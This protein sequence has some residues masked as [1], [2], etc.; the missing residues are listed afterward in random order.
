MSKQNNSDY[1]LSISGWISS[2][3]IHDTRQVVQAREGDVIL[4]PTRENLDANGEDINATSSFNMFSI[5]SRFR[6]KVDGP[7][8]FGAK[9]SLC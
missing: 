4:Y 1:K 6:I 2:E 9:S 8:I 7:E 5:H 3:T